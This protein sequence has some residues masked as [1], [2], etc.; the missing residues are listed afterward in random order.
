MGFLGNLTIRQKI[1]GGGLL[2][3]VSF[4]LIGYS[5]V[6]GLSAV[7]STVDRM[8]Q[9]ATPAAL[10]S[11]RVS[12]E[13]RSTVGAL[14]FHLLGKEPAD[15][16]A[17]KDGLKRTAELIGTL[18]HSPAI[19]G[20]QRSA[21][22][23]SQ[24]DADLQ[25]LTA[26]APGLLALTEND[27]NNIPAIAFANEHTN[28]VF[29]SKLQQLSTLVDAELAYEPDEVESGL[30]ELLQRRELL[31]T[32]IALRY[33]W[34]TLNNEVRL[35]LAFR[36]PAAIDNIATYSD[37]V[38]QYA[39]RLESFSDIFTFEQEEAFAGFIDGLDAFWAAQEKLLSI[40][41]A[42]DWRRDSYLIRTEISPLV[43]HM[44]TALQSLVGR[45]RDQITAAAEHTREIYTGIR[46]QTIL[47]IGVLGLLIGVF[48]WLV[49]GAITRPIGRAVEVAQ[50]IAQGEL[51]N[52]IEGARNDETGQL[53]RSL[54]TMQRDLRE[55]LEADAA[56]A[57]ENLRIRFAL[58]SVNSPVT[59]SGEDNSLIYMNGAAEKLFRDL[60]EEWQR[61]KPAFSA[62]RLLGSALSDYF[63]D[64]ALLDAYRA[65]LSGPRTIEGELAGHQMRLEASPVY[66]QDGS[67]QGRVT[68]WTDRTEELHEAELERQRIE[69]EREVAAEN[70][71]IRVALD[72][73]S[74]NMMMA[75]DKR[76]IVY[77]NNAAAHLFGEQS[78]SLP[79]S[80][81]E[82]L[83][84]D[85]AAA[86]TRIDSLSNVCREEFDREG[87]TLRTLS[88]P[89]LDEQGQRLG[90]AVEW[91]DRTAEVAI[92]REIDQ[93]VEAAVDGDL[94]RRL[95][96]HGKQGFQASLSVGF[97]SL[98]DQLESVF[99][100]LSS[101][102]G[103]LAQGDLER[104]IEKEY[105][106]AFGIARDNMNSTLDNLFGIVNELNAESIKVGSTAEEIN[107]GNTNLSV[108]TERQAS[109][110]QQTASSMEEFTATV[111][112]T[113]DNARRANQVAT[114]AR[115]K[116]EEGG[117]VV[118][119]AIQAMQ[120]I[121]ESSR[122]IAEIIGVID[123]IAFQTNLLA[124]NAS[125][126]AARAGEQGRGFAVVATEVRNLASRSAEAAKEIK[127]LITD[128][129][130]KVDTGSKLVNS[131]GETLDS[132]V[133]AV[134]KVGDIIADIDAASTEQRAGIS[135]VNEAIT[136]IDELT[137]QNAA[138]AE[139]TSSASQAM[140][141]N[142]RAM[143][144]HMGFFKL[145]EVPSFSAPDDPAEEHME[146]V[147][148]AACAV[149][150]AYASGSEPVAP[151]D[152]TDDWEEF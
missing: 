79:G 105:R 94:G 36:V 10:R 125:V 111:T 152:E 86:A 22:L 137:Q 64:G 42:D 47:V 75:D 122:R 103:A 134:K 61:I 149:S 118:G 17:F 28:P 70:Q 65:R 29:R 2:A 23:L 54:D 138:L 107:A 147:P 121:N 21:E 136:S 81:I 45:Q 93:L 127:E 101:S 14:G 108:R 1:I 51:N 96:E 120:Q 31:E 68:Q 12:E 145:A 131:S 98:L 60:E 146:E 148:A 7:Q 130:S 143:R 63:E 90:T 62:D 3:L 48:S 140:S 8:V 40:H 124:L 20:D 109:S 150:I 119:N 72:N 55:R 67:Y 32:L 73:A 24:V 13:V 18:E 71:R 44:T 110:L 126:E 69:A 135:Q 52:E 59:V 85:P 33:R 46:T 58:D 27:A 26:K 100:E 115:A 84:P 128:S 77:I 114:E 87:K 82:N 106:G 39:A 123:E 144:E 35:Y 56:I 4:I 49:V 78:E 50:A 133:E 102:L 34:I 37:A 43:T 9:E 30:D 97:N 116:A 74:S 6:N 16:Q 139:Q 141:Q 151:I 132:I 76:R 113:A 112:N 15:A 104:R 117:E 142:A 91:V 129:V 19:S 5:S 80:P 41:G 83:F 66:D 95:D 11:Y 53:M 57:A 38:K 88:A 89:V 92:E 99:G 25:Q